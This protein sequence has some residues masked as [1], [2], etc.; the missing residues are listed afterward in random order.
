MRLFL[1]LGS[2][3]GDR[4]AQLRFART[5]ISRR[6]IPPA[7]LESASLY[8]SAPV[9]C[10]P[11]S[12]AF[13]NTVLAGPVDL[14]PEQILAVTQAIEI[15]AGRNRGAVRN[16]PRPLD[17]DILLLDDIVF[18]TENLAIPHP[19]LHLRGFVLHPLAELAPN[20]VI[21]GLGAT[22]AALRA[23]LDASELPPVKWCSPW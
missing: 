18:R 13:L 2:N 19:R 12:G 23:G 22:V 14:Q 10:P 9:D 20:L 21:P 1:A 6:L 7:E 17:I 8:E 3:L 5:E 4:A 16:A 11:G 15:A